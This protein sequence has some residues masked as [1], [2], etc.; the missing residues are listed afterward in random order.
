MVKG[1]AETPEHKRAVIERIYNMWCQV[2]SQRLGQ[3]ISNA[4]ACSDIFSDIFYAE[5]ETLANAIEEY[6]THRVTHNPNE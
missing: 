2:P 4:S 3:L 5:D 1:R 6:V